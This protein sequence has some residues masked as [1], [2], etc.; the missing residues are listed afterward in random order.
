MRRVYK[1]AP[2][3]EA[4]VD[5]QFDPVPDEEW[6]FRIPGKLHEKLGAAY[7]GDSRQQKTISASFTAGEQPTPNIGIKESIARIQLLNKA[8]DRIVGVG[9]NSLMVS[10]LRPYDSWDHFRPRIASALDALASVSTLRPV[11]RIGLRYINRFSVNSKVYEIADFLPFVVHRDLVIEA[12]LKNA[13][14]RTEF[15][16]DDGV[17]LLLNQ[18]VLPGDGDRHDLVLDVDLVWQLGP[19]SDCKLIMG[20]IDD[21]HEREGKVFEALITDKAR[22]LFDGKP[23]DQPD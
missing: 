19:L 17:V 2:I 5:L 7:D 6:D 10:T 15:Q 3:D 18:A 16:Y 11:K 23:S 12:S 14:S 4:L 13:L 1:T 22:L 20:I 8:R 9:P 21:L